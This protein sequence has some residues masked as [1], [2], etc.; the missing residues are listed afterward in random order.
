[1]DIGGI[2]ILDSI[3]LR[4]LH[5]DP[6]AMLLIVI[7]VVVLT[8]VI[9]GIW[10]VTRAWPAST[11]SEGMIGKHAVAAEDFNKNGKVLLEGEYWKARAANAIPAG[12]TVVV[13]GV[14][15]L[16]LLVEPAEEE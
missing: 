5:M 11:G 13:T 15:G 1:M 8:A 9:A 6:Y 12:A 4:G 3:D 2:I 16:V 7:G 14:R 10:L